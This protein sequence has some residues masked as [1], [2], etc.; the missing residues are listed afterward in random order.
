[1]TN[2]K[3]L[4]QVAVI[5][6]FC[7]WLS[8]SVYAHTMW[9]NASNYSPKFSPERDAK[10]KVYFGWGHR[11]PVADFLS[12]ERL[13]EFSL[14]VPN[15]EKE[16]L[17]PNPGGFLATEL[18]LSRSGAYIAIASLKP[19][20]Y[21]VYLDDKGKRRHKLA[22]K[23]GIKGVIKSIHFEQYAK[24]LI[25]VGEVSGNP[26]ST[27]V[28]HK[29]EIV[30]LKNPHGLKPGDWLP[31]QVLFKGKPVQCEVHA[32]YI[33]YH[34]GEAFSVSTDG[35]GRAR[36]RVLHH[37]GPWIVKAKVK[38]PP[39]EELKERCN[40]LSCTGTLTFGVQ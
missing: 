11:Y 17:N 29:L 37:Y 22:P 4:F 2:I 36:I 5:L 20:F 9:L 38:L 39:S 27:P 33:G 30:P 34:T 8:T 24:A 18:N 7:L 3:R 32:A 13:E 1:M 10:T 31:I 25:N 19:G 14:I 12:A 15:G 40:E 26:F 6:G 28:G 21:T 16:K 23:T 35:E